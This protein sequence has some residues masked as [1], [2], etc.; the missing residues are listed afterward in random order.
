MFARYP[1]RF[2]PKDRNPTHK[3]S[4][5][6]SACSSVK[7]SFR[8]DGRVDNAQQSHYSA[9]FVFTPVITTLIESVEDNPV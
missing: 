6:N 2:V 3:F 9:V 4:T 1:F 8:S 7:D 5:A